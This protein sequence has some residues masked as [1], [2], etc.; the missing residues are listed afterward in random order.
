MKS[1]AT[2][3]YLKKNSQGYL[4][5][6]PFLVI[7]F[8]FTVWPVILSMGLSLTTYNVFQAPKFLGFENYVK[9][10]FGDSI[11]LTAMQNTFL[12]SLV[13]GPLSYFLSLFLAWMVNE[14]RNPWKTILTVIFYAPTCPVLCIPSG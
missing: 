5:M 7:F 6:L 12:L 2:W 13:V 9:L 11:F 8:T 14:F 3:R 4:L 1:N 10:F